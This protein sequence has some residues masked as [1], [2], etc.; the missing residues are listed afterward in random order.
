MS[1]TREELRNLVI[2]NT[3]RSDKVA[4]IN[5]ALSLAMN[6]ISL[7]HTFRQMCV[8][9]SGTLSINDASLTLPTGA[10]DLMEL[11]LIDPDTSTLTH[12]IVL[13]SKSW[14]LSRWPNPSSNSSGTPCI[15]YLESNVLV[16]DR[17]V[18]KAY[19]Y[20]GTYLR[21][22]RALDDDT[23][24]ADCPYID[25]ALVC[26][27]T[28]YVFRSIQDQRSAD[29]WLMQYRVAMRDA[30]AF[31]GHRPGMDIR[32]EEF[33]RAADAELGRRRVVAEAPIQMDGGL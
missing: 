17:P 4:L 5:S 23:D 11:R 14:I 6:D 33:T 7:Q 31:D 1:L 15:A 20:A 24:T 19:T 29:S 10:V 26:W 21:M 9:F 3:G 27:A 13:K 18:V 25:N 22:L 2:S 32:A 8:V 28:A 12:T 16:F 30:K